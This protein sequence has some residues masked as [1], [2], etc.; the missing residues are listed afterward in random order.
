MGVHFERWATCSKHASP[1]LIS[2]EVGDGGGWLMLDG[3]STYMACFSS[4]SSLVPDLAG[5]RSVHSAAEASF[6]RL[7]IEASQT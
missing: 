2:K 1:S 6:D 4:L 3:H 5:Y 7:W